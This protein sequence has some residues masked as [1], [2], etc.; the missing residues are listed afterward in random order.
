VTAAIVRCGRLLVAA[1]AFSMFPLASQDTGRVPIPSDQED[2]KLPSGKLQSEEI[3]K[4]DFNNSLRDLDRI[5]KLAGEIK[6]EMEKKGRLVL[7]IPLTKKTE[8]MEKLAK[9]IRGRMLK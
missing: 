8:E 7:S 9:R 6:I 4:A 5:S 1:T 2:T 3:L